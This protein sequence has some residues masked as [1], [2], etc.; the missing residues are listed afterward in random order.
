MVISHPRHTDC[1]H[2]CIYIYIY[3]YIYIFIIY[4]S[5]LYIYISRASHF[6]ESLDPVY[7]V[8]EK[9]CFIGVYQES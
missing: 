8:F 5:Y 9:T 1:F 7:S 6:G 3:I 4:I 2:D